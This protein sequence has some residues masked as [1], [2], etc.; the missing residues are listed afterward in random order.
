M[1]EDQAIAGLAPVVPTIQIANE[2]I[3]TIAAMAA[4]EVHGVSGLSGGIAAGLND[5]L[6]RKPTHRGVRVEVEGRSVELALNLVV[7]YGV[8]IPEIAQNVQ[9][10]VKQQVEMATGLSVR[11][12]DIH[13]Q[14]VA[15]TELGGDDRG[16][17]NDED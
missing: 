15:S 6:G 14:G 5:I 16:E 1:Q 3:G 4:S 9:E 11:L 2:V 12:V 17:T 10:H 8:R 7:Q 13:I